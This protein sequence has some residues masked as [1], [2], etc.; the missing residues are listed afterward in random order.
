M[1]WSKLCYEA[2]HVLVFMFAQPN[3]AAMDGTFKDIL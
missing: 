2:T 1:N 3:L